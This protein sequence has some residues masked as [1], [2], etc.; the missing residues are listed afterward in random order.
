MVDKIRRI[1]RF[2]S[3]LLADVIKKLD[4]VPEGNGTLLDNTMLV[5]GS[6]ISDGNRHNHDR[7]PVIVAGG[8]AAGFNL[9]QHIKVPDGTPMCNLYTGMLEKLTHGQLKTPF[10]DAT[11]A[12]VI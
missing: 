10:G 1:N 3:S 4:A 8:S 11:G 12:L 5:W 9:G 2:Q 6:A 7:L